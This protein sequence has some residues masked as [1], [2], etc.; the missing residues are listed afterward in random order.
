LRLFNKYP[1]WSV[2]GDFI[3]A[4]TEEKGK[5][6]FLARVFLDSWYRYTIRLATRQSQ[7]DKEYVLKWYDK[8]KESGIKVLPEI[9]FIFGVR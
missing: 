9:P 2:A 7:E 4:M 3:K 5:L 1:N 8:A 6:E